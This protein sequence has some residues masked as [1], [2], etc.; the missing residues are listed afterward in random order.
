MNRV[1]ARPACPVLGVMSVTVP[2]L[3][4]ISHVA[5]MLPWMMY[6]SY[7]RLFMLQ[8]RRTHIIVEIY[9]TERSYVES[10][11]TLVMV[12]MLLWYKTRMREGK[13]AQPHVIMALD[14]IEQSARW[15]GTKCSPSFDLCKLEWFSKVTDYG[16]D[17]DLRLDL[18]LNCH[19]FC[20][21]MGSGINSIFCRNLRITRLHIVLMLKNKCCFIFTHLSFLHGGAQF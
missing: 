9:D 12:S 3:Q 21:Q 20:H 16:Q 10:L 19:S 4:C 8:D 17:F 5:C 18:R 13:T 2:P 14:G 15:M 6:L 1:T 7:V 11:Q